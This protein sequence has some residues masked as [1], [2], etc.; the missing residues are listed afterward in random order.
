VPWTTSVGQILSRVWHKIGDSVLFRI[1]REKLI[2]E[3]KW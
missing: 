3:K 2:I 1:N